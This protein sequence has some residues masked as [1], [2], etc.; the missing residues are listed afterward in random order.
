MAWHWHD[1]S[2]A[3]HWPLPT[4]SALS[5]TNSAS[6]ANPPLGVEYHL[7]TLT[8]GASVMEALQDFK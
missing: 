5:M 6:F 2:P 3:M 8:L 7:V 4:A 1:D